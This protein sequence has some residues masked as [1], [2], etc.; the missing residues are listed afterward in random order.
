MFAWYDLHMKTILHRAESRGRGEYG[1]LSTRYSFSFAEWHDMSRMGFGALRVLNDD[2]VA[3]NSGF[4]EHRHQ[5]M[6]IITIVSSGAVM[7]EDNMGNRREVR[8]GEVQVMSAGTGVTHSEYNR[9]PSETLE[10]FQLWITPDYTG[11]P[12]RYAE[13]T[14]PGTENSFRLLV[15]GDPRLKDRADGPLYINQRASVYHGD[16]YEHF[17]GTHQFEDGTRGAYVFMIDGSAMVAGETLERRDAIGI[18]GT[19]AFPY[20][21]LDEASL[22]LIDVPLVTYAGEIL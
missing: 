9:S 2:R 1:W 22:L 16:F 21:I 3:P 14:F 4:P 17:E 15:S 8:A 13:R 7:H 20:E 10:L 5:D 12:P 6:E 11:H 18:F 19:T